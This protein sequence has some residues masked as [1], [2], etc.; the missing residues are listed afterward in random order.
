MR[1][2]LPHRWR[3][4]PNID[5][6]R[7]N[8]SPDLVILHYT[9]MRSSAAAV[10]WLCNPVSKVSSHYVVDGRGRIDQ[11]VEESDRA[12]HAGVSCWEGES[13][14]N[15]RSIGIEIHNPGHEFGYVDFPAG[16]IDAV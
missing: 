14:T 13:D 5:A 4:S 1:T 7:G 12:W 16:Q 2:L 9:G 8:R 15:S 10:D 3:R 11:L 6:R